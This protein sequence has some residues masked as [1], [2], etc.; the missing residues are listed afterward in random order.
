MDPNQSPQ[1][2]Q[3]PEQQ[4][5]S[6]VLAQ[7]QQPQVV[8]NAQPLPQQVIQP[9]A[10][11][12][13]NNPQV[14]TPAPSIQASEGLPLSDQSQVVQQP[15]QVQANPTTAP[16]VIIDQPIQAAPDNS[17]GLSNQ[18]PVVT[19][20]PGLATQPVA[21]SL[22]VSAPV[23]PQNNETS[24]KK[25]P[26]V[27][28]A[29]QLTFRGSE[30]QKPKS[31]IA[32]IFGI[33]MIIIALAASAGCI[34]ATQHIKGA[35]QAIK[36]Y[37]NPY[38]AKK[39]SDTKKAI[40]ESGPD[41]QKLNGD[42]LDLSKLFEASIAEHAQDIKGKVKEQIN[43]S[44]GVSFAVTGIE[45]GW[46]TGDDYYKPS[47]NKEYIKVAVTAGYRGKTGS[48]SV[49]DSSFKLLNS[50]GGLQDNRYLSDKLLPDN[51]LSSGSTTLNPGDAHSGWVVY[52]I[53]KGEQVTLVYEKKGYSYADGTSKEFIMKGS[54]ELK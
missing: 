30:E 40:K 24:N 9:S 19:A 3:Q 16:S 45:R 1:Q 21:P 11:P 44:D 29:A 18:P 47:K 20:M 22:G 26:L 4:P 5:V 34:Y 50:K 14:I 25:T 35:R 27:T 32:K 33:I 51:E 10:Q 23:A 54:V 38:A 8:D 43:I 49:S 39:E 12:V 37:S 42:K 31:L 53:D 7:A 41:T 36:E 2:N 48:G 13:V 52:E 6:P 46:S 15:G 28:L 17:A